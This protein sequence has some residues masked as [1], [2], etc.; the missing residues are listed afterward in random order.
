LSNYLNK[1]KLTKLP[2]LDSEALLLGLSSA[3]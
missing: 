1:E 2:L 3:L